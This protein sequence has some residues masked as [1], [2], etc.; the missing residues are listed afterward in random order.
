MQPGGRGRAPQR[1]DD[2]GEEEGVDPGGAV[3]PHLDVR[4]GAA[5]A[6]A[7]LGP[8]GCLHHTAAGRAAPRAEG[9]V[10]R[11]HGAA[12]HQGEEAIRQG[13]LAAGYW[14]WGGLCGA[15]PSSALQGCMVTESGRPA[16]RTPAHTTKSTKP[17]NET[18]THKEDEVS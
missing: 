9:K 14:A 6:A 2:R 10:G 18:D 17:W 15:G 3:A 11:T 1:A 12:S 5:A 8:A 16:E 4:G 13:P 7:R